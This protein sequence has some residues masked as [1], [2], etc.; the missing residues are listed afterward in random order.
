MNIPDTVDH[1]ISSSFYHEGL[2]SSVTAKLSKLDSGTHRI[3]PSTLIDRCRIPVD[4]RV[5]NRLRVWCK[6]ED[7]TFACT[8]LA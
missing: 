4:K 6:A 2:P 5:H 1:Q 3:Y 7:D 8:I